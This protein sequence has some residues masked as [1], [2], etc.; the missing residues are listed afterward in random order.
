MS[1]FRDRFS[2]ESKGLFWSSEEKKLIHAGE[3]GR[4]REDLCADFLRQ[5]LPRHLAI[6]S[7]F[8]V[9]PENNRSTQ[10]DLIIYDNELT[11]AISDDESNYFFPVDCVLAVG[12]IKSDIS[13]KVELTDILAK[14]SA[15]KTLSKE[16]SKS[17]ASVDGREYQRQ[18]HM[19]DI[20][21]FV[22]CNSLKWKADTLADDI[23]NM[24]ATKSVERR[25]QH[26]L[27]FSLSDGLHL[28]RNGSGELCAYPALDKETVSSF[29]PGQDE[30]I[31]K[32]FL[33][34]F[35]TPIS[36]IQRV[37]VDIGSYL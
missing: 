3:Y 24:Y 18:N 30:E 29:K 11:P 5:F 6:G 28:Y 35:Y 14:L 26:N 19:N 1:R 34:T 22:I 8:I 32:L 20:F 36:F 2:H 16:R 17:S 25:Y 13:S 12:E 23:S 33:A 21:T 31:N 4:Y 10:C 9:T 7:G 37:C 27:I 15:V